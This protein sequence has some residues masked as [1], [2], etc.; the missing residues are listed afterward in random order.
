MRNGFSEGIL[1]NISANQFNELRS[2]TPLLTR[3][4]SGFTMVEILI[5]LA[6]VALLAAVAMPTFIKARESARTNT[7]IANLKKIDEAKQQWAMENKQPATALP[8]STDLIGPNLY[9]RN[10]PTCPVDTANT[11]ASSYT[12]GNVSANPSCQKDSSNH[13]LFP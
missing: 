4:K 13:V 6:T 5:V 3:V 8:A 12:I 1:N 7:C 11:F 9:I 10:P 2:Y